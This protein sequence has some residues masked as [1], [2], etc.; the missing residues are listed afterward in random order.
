MNKMTFTAAA[1]LLAA[2]AAN[3]QSTLT[4]YGV[5]DVAI[6]HYR[7]EGTGSRT[8][9]TSGSNQQSRLGFRGKE[10]LGGGMA[11][12]FELE[13]GVSND[14]GNGQATNTNNQTSGATVAGGL[15]FNRKSFV[16]LAGPWGE[17]RLGRDYVPTFWI[18]FAYDP[19]RTGVGFG[20]ATTQGAS[21]TTALRASNSIQYLTRQCYAYECEG[22]HLQTMLALGENAS[23]T[24]NSSDGRVTG[25]RLGYG[26][27]NWDVAV[28]QTRTK[29]VAAGDFKQTVLGGS[30]NFSGGRLLL[31]AG[32]HSTGL[33]FAGLGNGTKADFWQVGAFINAGPGTIPVAFTRVKRND[34]GEGAANKLAFGYVYPFSKRTAIYA[35]YAHISNK[36]SMQLPVNNGADVGP[37]PVR[38]GSASGF[39]IGLRHSF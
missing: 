8:L 17:V 20:G 7:G 12:G 38:G 30:W 10:D 24:P 36:G 19:F 28:G 9:V 31:Q 27:G 39:D 25:A 18:L 29:N 5:A 15:A 11:A 6:S 23:N 2:G 13:A 32:R 34:V 14:S 35:T 37:T 33:P 22:F 1:A 16:S 4:I 26:G 21:P 3:A